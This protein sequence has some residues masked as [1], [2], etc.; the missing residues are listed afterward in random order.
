[1]VK[2]PENT[3]DRYNKRRGGEGGGVLAFGTG[4]AQCQVPIR[5]KT[6]SAHYEKEV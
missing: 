5:R 3:G 1:M 2:T 4:C 6:N